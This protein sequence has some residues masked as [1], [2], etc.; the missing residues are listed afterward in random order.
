VTDP[1][2]IRTLR[3]LSSADVAELVG[4]Y[5]SGTRYDVLWSDRRDRVA[6]ALRR[7][8]LRTPYR[9][10]FPH[11]AEEL[12]RYR[13][14]VRLGWSV[15]AYQGGRL[16][17]LALAEPRAW[18]RSVWIWELGVAA[19]HRR[20]GVGMRLV[21]E[22][23]RRARKA[24]FRTLVCETQTTNGP[25]LEFYRRA[26]FRLEGVDVSYYSNEDLRT[27]EVAVFMKKRV[28]PA[29]KGPSARRRTSR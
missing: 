15:G 28:P 11:P 7:V 13:H 14:V 20:Q 24:G 5:T 21:G 17:G 6:F 2:R 18:N 22:L 8:R 3:G 16:I 23:T 1:V 27:G 12:R 29:R 25:A 26:G 4:G 10:F 9:K 19:S